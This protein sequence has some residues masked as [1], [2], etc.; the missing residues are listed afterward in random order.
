MGRLL[1]QCLV[2]VR[3]VSGEAPEPTTV[4]TLVVTTCG[5]PP[6]SSLTQEALTRQA[7]STGSGGYGLDGN[8][9]G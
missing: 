9:D 4:P 6:S 8:D 2:M 5:P 1:N 7:N 3:V